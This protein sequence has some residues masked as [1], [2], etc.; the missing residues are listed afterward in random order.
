[1]HAQTAVELKNNHYD[2]AS[3]TLH[4]DHAGKRLPTV[5]RLLTGLI[6]S[7]IPHVNGGLKRGLISDPTELHQFYRI[8]HMDGVASVTKP[9][10]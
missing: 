8:R 3:A 10:R 7:L 5:D 2:A 9:P 6:T 1:V 4:L